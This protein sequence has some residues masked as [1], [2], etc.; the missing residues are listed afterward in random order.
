MSLILWAF[1]LHGAH[2]NNLQNCKKYNLDFN[3]LAGD[4]LMAQIEDDIRGD[5]EKLGFTVNT[6]LLSKPD[7]NAGMQQ[8]NFSLC[9]TETWGPPYDPHSFAT[10]WFRP[11]NEAHYP[12]LDGL[13][14]PM[15]KSTLQ[16]MVS[17][18]VKKK[19]EVARQQGWTAILQEIH[20]QAISLPM[21]SR[22]MPAVWN[23]RLSNYRAG[24]QQ[25]D[26][27]IHNILVVSGSNTSMSHQARK[28]VFLSRLAQ[29]T[30]T[31]TVQMNSLSATGCTK[32][33]CPMVL[34]VLFFLNWPPDGQRVILLM[35]AR[36]THSLCVPG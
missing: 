22:R 12:A 20:K 36:S 31:V 30:L 24:E 32:A 28:Q 16:T 1:L 4:P 14:P 15:T 10:G 13:E 23:R 33:S 3:L 2:G 17:D 8:G 21:W 18:V 34:M 5:L 19:T 9:F 7:F 11:D 25:F 6:R 29:W 27:P 35:G 26:Y